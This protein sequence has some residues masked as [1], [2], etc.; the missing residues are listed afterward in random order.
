MASFISHCLG[1]LFVKTMSF[2]L[3]VITLTNTSLSCYRLLFQF[4]IQSPNGAISMKATNEDSR[5]QTRCVRLSRFSSENAIR[6][7]SEEEFC[8]PSSNRL[9]QTSLFKQ[10]AAVSYGSYRNKRFSALKF[11]LG[12]SNYCFWNIF[13][14]LTSYF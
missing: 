13:M 10:N 14:Q 3:L 1:V 5:K 8:A 11:D 9:Q 7:T 4:R 6:E 12:A 2:A